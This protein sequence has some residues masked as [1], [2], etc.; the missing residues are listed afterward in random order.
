MQNQKPYQ[1]LDP[2]VHGTI[3]YTFTLYPSTVIYASG[4]IQP[5]SSQS[6]ITLDVNQTPEY[7][8][9]PR[10][11]NGFTLVDTTSGESHIV[12]SYDPA[13]SEVTFEKPF[14]NPI[15]AGNSYEMYIGFPTKDY[16][17]IP[18]IDDNGNP[19][20]TEELAYNGYYVVFETPNP[21]LYSNPDNSNIFYRRISYYDNTIQIAY[22]DKPLPF[23]Y[24]TVTT[25]QT[26]TLRKSLP[27]E[28]WRL[29]SPTTMNVT[30]P[31]NPNIG[32]LIGMVIQLPAGASSVDNFYKGKYVY[33]ASNAPQTY[34]PPLPPPV[35]LEV[36]IPYIF[37]P[38]YGAYYIKAYNGTT[39]Q[40]SIDQDIRNIP[41]PTY[42]N[43]AYDSSSFVA[44]SGVSAITN[45]GGGVYRADFTGSGSSP[46]MSILLLNSRLYQRGR[47]YIITW[48]IRKSANITTTHFEVP[49]VIDYIST[50]LTN[51]YTTYTFRYSPLIQDIHFNFISDFNPAL[52]DLY[53]EWSDFSMIQEDT[54]NIST[55]AKDN[56]SPLFYTGTM[57]NQAVCY[58]MSLSS[59]SI[60]NLPLLTGSSVAFYPFLYILLENV[61]AP[62][63]S[64]TNV[65]YSNNPETAHALFIA[66]LSPTP[67]PSVQRYIALNSSVSHT[68]KFKPND[69]LRFAVYLSD[70]QLLR[71]L[72]P[73]ILSP[74]DNI[75]RNQI[76]AIFSINRSIHETK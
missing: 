20:A 14:I 72:I 63:A 32:P 10:Y 43:L 57:M 4:T 16:I 67:D 11:Y 29:S 27:T 65:I 34:S 13:S 44:D 68:I 15:T 21:T 45:M 53:V 59:L 49:G 30:P 60:P 9:V 55:F 42:I 22:F 35:E 50:D 47:T 19:I 38:I 75:P 74:Y 33:Y 51:G 3:Y 66:A 58:D 69:N 8:M 56:F 40:L 31:A 71:T 76:S 6:S 37:Y 25:A 62:S 46:Y 54:I 18:T 39:K 36:P 52:P 48:T 28:R 7:S 5:D 23:D 17:Y 64:S 24:S 12:Q 70:G 26:F 2:V 1:S 41:P 73:D 61:T